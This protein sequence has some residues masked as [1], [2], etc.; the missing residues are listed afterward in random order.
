ML[1]LVSILNE[2]L[3]VSGV[4][5]YLDSKGNWVIPAVEKFLKIRFH[6]KGPGIYE[7]IKDYINDDTAGLPMELIIHTK[8]N[9]KSQ[10]E[11]QLYHGF[12]HFIEY[13]KL[14]SEIQVIPGNGIRLGDMQYDKHI[15]NY[16]LGKIA[17]GTRP[18]ENVNDFRI[19]KELMIDAYGPNLLLVKRKNPKKKYWH[20]DSYV[21]KILK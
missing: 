6:H 17:M 18:V 13:K 16:P 4:N 12:K 19:W 15:R 14:I 3:P 8:S 10:I 7:L 5:P 20:E 1:S 21:L 11:D 2:I 9:K